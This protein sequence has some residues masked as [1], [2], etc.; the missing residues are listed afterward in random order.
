MQQ[1]MQMQQKMRTQPEMQTDTLTAAPFGNPA[2]D[3]V[4]QQ[5]QQMRQMHLMLQQQQMRTQ[6]EMQTGTLPTIGLALALGLGLS[7]MARWR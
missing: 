2:D 1:Q 7:S 4:M 5:L 6:P 3:Q